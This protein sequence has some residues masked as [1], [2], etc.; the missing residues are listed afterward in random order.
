MNKK[1]EIIQAFGCFCMR[2]GV[3][4]YSDFFFFWFPRISKLYCSVLKQTQILFI[5]G[6][7]LGKILNQILTIDIKFYLSSLC[8]YIGG[9]VLSFSSVVC[10]F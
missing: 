5:A 3:V 8:V 10:V 1:V 4:Q 7:E 2:I 9:S 6:V